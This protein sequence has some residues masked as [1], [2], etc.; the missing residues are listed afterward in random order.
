MLT[1][2]S[3]RLIVTNLEQSK[4][5]NRLGVRPKIVTH[6]WVLVDNPIPKNLDDE[7]KQDKKWR[8]NS[9]RTLDIPTLEII[10]AF[11]VQ[12]LLDL[13]GEDVVL[14]RCQRMYV[15]ANLSICPFQGQ[16]KLKESYKGITVIEALYHMLVAK[17]VK[18]KQ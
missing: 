6:S 11:T 12:N 4:H 5:L 14:F 10:P 9:G 18:D 1:N 16:F 13:I 15:C 7:T 17:L 8:L 2:L 3:N